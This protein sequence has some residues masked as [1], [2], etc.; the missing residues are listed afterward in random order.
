MQEVILLAA[1][2]Q[3]VKRI[4]KANYQKPAKVFLWPVYPTYGL[5]PIYAQGVLEEY[6]FKI[7]HKRIFGFRGNF[8]T[9]KQEKIFVFSKIETI[10]DE[11]ITKMVPQG[12]KKFSA[13]LRKPA[14]LLYHQQK[15]AVVDI[16]WEE[17]SWHVWQLLLD[18]TKISSLALAK[19]QQKRLAEYF[20]VV[21]QKAK[22]AVALV[23]RNYN[24]QLFFRNLRAH[25]YQ[26]SWSQLLEMLVVNP[27]QFWQYPQANVYLQSVTNKYRV[28]DYIWC[29]YHQDE[30][31]HKTRL[32]A[33][34]YIFCEKTITQGNN[35]VLQKKELQKLVEKYLHTKVPMKLFEKAWSL[36]LDKMHLA[37]TGKWIAPVKRYEWAKQIYDLCCRLLTKQTPNIV[38][39]ADK[40]IKYNETQEW[41]IQHA[42]QKG[43]TLITGGPGTGKTTIMQAILKTLQHHY[44][45]HEI[46]L[47]APTGKAAYRIR[48]VTQWDWVSTIHLLKSYLAN[49]PAEHIKVLMID[50]MSMVTP[51]LLAAICRACPF[52]EKLILIGDKNQLPSIEPGNLFADLMN[53]FADNLIELTTVYRQ[54]E[55]SLLLPLSHFI[56]TNNNPQKKFDFGY[57]T[58]VVAHDLWNEYSARTRLLRV[59]SQYRL[60]DFYTKVQIVTNVYQGETGIWKLNYWMQRSFNE[61]NERRVFWYYQQQFRVGD[62]VIQEVNNYE[63]NVFNGDVGYIVAVNEDYSGK[64]ND[65]CVEIV[66]NGSSIL[67]T[68]KMMQQISLGYVCSVHKVQGGEYEHLLYVWDKSS[69]WLMN[70]QLIYTAV[71]RAKQRL[72]LIGPLGLFWYK[73]R[74]IVPTPQTWLHMWQEQKKEK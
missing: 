59:C 9:E 34:S 71:T 17:G 13:A 66:M 45:P 10:S 64:P 42:L 2:Y 15:K 69:S 48:Q 24:Y 33:L 35:T 38:F 41:A 32:T 74:V 55:T 46:R 5:E 26:Y 72:D 39:G 23:H 68:F 8:V 58:Q 73:C 63:I 62:K 47:V 14:Q 67:Y 44:V 21:Q 53:L 51:W 29:F 1:I 50:E 16:L 65:W 4:T 18:E 27:Y 56:L 7:D 57:S 12:Y 31:L 20:T 43:L 37:Q 22:L 52:L 28:L 3:T 25:A 11:T 19:K 6:G 61:R 49:H 54:A 70:K 30:L 36:G 40:Q 60:N